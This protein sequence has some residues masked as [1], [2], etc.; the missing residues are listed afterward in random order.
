MKGERVISPHMSN[1]PSKVL[2]YIFLDL[3]YRYFL[4]PSLVLFVRRHP[5][6]PRRSQFGREEIYPSQTEASKV[7]KYLLD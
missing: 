6:R 2:F 5:R 3:D 7:H 1:S 4:N